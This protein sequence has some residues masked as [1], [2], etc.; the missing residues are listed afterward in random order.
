VTR[1]RRDEHH[2]E[3]KYNRDILRQRWSKYL[4]PD[5]SDYYLLAEIEAGEGKT[6]RWLQDVPPGTVARY[7]LPERRAV[8]RP[9]YRIQ[10]GSG[11][12]PEA[13]YLHLDAAPDAPSVDIIHDI[14]EPLPFLDGSVGEILTSDIVG[15]LSPQ[16]LLQVI[17]DFHRVLSKDGRLVIRT[18]NVRR[19]A[20]DYLHRRK[21]SIFLGANAPD[22]SPSAGYTPVE[23]AEAE[24]V[25]N[26]GRCAE[27]RDESAE[28]ET[29]VGLCRVAGF[30]EARYV[31]VVGQQSSGE[32]LVVA[33]H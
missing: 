30:S 14:V 12:H 13:G 16:G 1:G 15:R 27:F 3:E 21:S 28:G 23:E 29:L 31:P 22:L 17:G 32:S 10:I 8:G 7:D 9:P 24:P 19:I 4:A 20:E 11:E 33:L 26:G 25:A 5:I 6:W 2:P 18:G